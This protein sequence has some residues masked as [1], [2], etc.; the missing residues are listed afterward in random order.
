[1]KFRISKELALLYGIIAGDGCLSECVGKKFISITC[2]FYDDKP[3][4]D[5]I[6]IPLLNKIRKGKIT[7]YR[8]RFDQGKIEINFTDAR[9]FTTLKDLEFPVGKKGVTL[10]ISD[11]I[12]RDLWKYSLAGIFATDGCLVIKNNNGT[13]YPRIEIQSISNTLL[14]Q[15]KSFLIENGMKGNVYKLDRPFGT[16]YRLEFPGKGNLIKF[17]KTIGFVNPK[18]ENRYKIYM[19]PERIGLS[20]FK[21]SIGTL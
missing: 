6:V 20:A 5:N 16:I 19:G 11:S 2:N 1:M 9:L 3:F 17:R 21:Q 8:D 7:K 14:Q 13:L 12:P 10:R 18:H 4:F 15:I